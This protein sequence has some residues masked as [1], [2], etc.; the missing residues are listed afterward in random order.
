LGKQAHVRYIKEA[1]PMNRR[2]ALKAKKR[3]RKNSRPCGS[4]CLPRIR[5][6]WRC[7][8]AGGLLTPNRIAGLRT[9]CSFWFA[10][11]LRLQDA[12]VR[13]LAFFVSWFSC[14]VRV[15]CQ[16]SVSSFPRS[17]VL[18]CASFKKKRQV[19]VI[20]RSFAYIFD[21]VK[22]SISFMCLKG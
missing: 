6:K 13:K 9:V 12:E 20:Y 10:S 21:V 1:F 8:E 15:A 18:G 19:I 17:A 4:E 3:V 11:E 2:S 7:G 22:E 14:Q 5:E 16:M